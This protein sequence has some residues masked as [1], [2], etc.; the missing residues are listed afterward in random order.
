MPPKTKIPTITFTRLSE[1]LLKIPLIESGKLLFNILPSNGDEPLIWRDRF[2]TIELVD[3]DFK[4]VGLLVWD[5]H[6]PDRLHG[7]F[8]GDP[9]LV[10]EQ[11]KVCP[12]VLDLSAHRFLIMEEYTWLDS[13]KELYLYFA[14]ATGIGTIDFCITGIESDTPKFEEC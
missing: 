8:L 2:V 5:I 11:E 6:H 14:D 4:K 3:S 1:K 7:P 12:D 13:S 9:E 10:V